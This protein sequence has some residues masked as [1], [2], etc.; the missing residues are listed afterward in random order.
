MQRLFGQ[1][2]AKEARLKLLEDY[3]TGRPPLPWGSEDTKAK[4]YRFQQTARSNF[5]SLIVQAPCD[6]CGVRSIST[7]VDH[8]ENGDQQA[9]Q[10]FTSNDLDIHFSD[11]TRMA[12]KWGEAFMAVGMPDPEEGTGQAVITAEDPR[13]VICA[14]DPMRPR[15]V[16]AAFKLYHDDVDGLDIAILWL[17]GEKWVATRER[18]IA[19]NPLVRPGGILAPVEPIPVS[20]TAG[21]Y[22][23]AP[24]RTG[25]AVDGV[26]S[27]SY[28]VQDIPVVPFRNREGTGEFE[29]HTDLLDR[30]NHMILQRIV[31]ATMQ[32]FKQR[33]I[34]VLS[35]EDLPERDDDGN[36]IDYDDIFAAD[37]GAL[38]KLPAGAKIWE[39]GQVDLTGVLAGTKDDVLHLAALTRTPL[40]MFTPDAATQT[41]EGASLQREGLTFKVEEYLRGANRSLS[42]VMSL[43][44]QFMGDAVRGDLSQ[45]AVD[46][47]PAE[48]YSLAEQGAAASQAATSLT[49]EQTQRI[50]WQ[51]TPAQIA[52]A[53]SQRA[54]DLLLSQHMAATQ[55]AQMVKPAPVPPATL[56]DPN[57]DDSAA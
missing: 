57:V 6:R 1:L 13:Q 31:I 37:P 2:R 8:D 48:R 29:L 41:A 25:D 10:L 30:I 9:W 40:S 55:A 23:M 43:G 19:T 11:V 42:R 45:I 34:E 15:K 17:P 5:A 26:F 4:F 44:F 3:Y 14:M 22:D 27:E 52:E 16:V 49:W 35:A 21:G 33:A 53:K 28:A 56:G 32:A 7:A 54:D 20:F 24:M 47:L 18:M 46:W 51:Q 39:S 36:V 50:I 12:F 38:W